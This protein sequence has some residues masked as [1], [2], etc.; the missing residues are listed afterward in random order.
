MRVRNREYLPVRATNVT[1]ANRG[2]KRNA[3]SAAD[4]A[5]ALEGAGEPGDEKRTQMP[6]VR[7][8]L[9]CE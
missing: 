1:K 9:G 4:R 8:K 2:R 6:W 3:K 7:S 5:D